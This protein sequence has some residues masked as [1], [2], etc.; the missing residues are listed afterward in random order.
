[1]MM[2]ER[3][4]VTYVRAQYVD[5]GEGYRPVSSREIEKKSH[6]KETSY[7]HIKQY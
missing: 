3:E 1:M 5:R 6:I 4:R 7:I 2:E